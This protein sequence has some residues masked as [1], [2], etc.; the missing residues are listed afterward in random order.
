MARLLLFRYRK[1]KPTLFKGTNKFLVYF[2]FQFLGSYHFYDFAN[3]NIK[4]NQQ[5]LAMNFKTTL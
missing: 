3:R 1:S 5:K 4:E 2:V